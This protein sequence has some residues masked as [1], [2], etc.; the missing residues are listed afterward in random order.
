MPKEH[1]GYSSEDCFRPLW[2]QSCKSVH[3][4]L[5]KS[6]NRYESK[7]KKK[8]CHT[9][10]LLN[11]PKPLTSCLNDATGEHVP[12]TVANFEALCKHLS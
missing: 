3:L 1:A 5:R 11:R 10:I 12:K 6:D 7:V 9:G 2:N 4:K 8:R